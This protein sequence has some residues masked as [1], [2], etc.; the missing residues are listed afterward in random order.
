VT[1]PCRSEYIPVLQLTAQRSGP[2]M[3][4]FLLFMDPENNPPGI[5]EDDKEAK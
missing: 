4:Y 2:G 3:G 5:W 1:L